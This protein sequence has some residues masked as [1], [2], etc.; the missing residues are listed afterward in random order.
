MITQPPPLQDFQ[1][2]STR[3]TRPPS[4]TKT[5]AGEL[6][7][8]GFYYGMG[9]WLGWLVMALVVIALPWLLLAVFLGAGLGLGQLLGG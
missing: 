2:E 8:C 4:R 5:P 3:R 6:F 1:P 7:R 9:Q